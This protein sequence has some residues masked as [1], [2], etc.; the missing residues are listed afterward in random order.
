MRSV[1]QARRRAEEM[2]EGGST[3]AYSQRFHNCCLTEGQCGTDII[4][5]ECAGEPRL[6]CKKEKYLIGSSS[7]PSGSFLPDGCSTQI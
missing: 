2:A 1:C 6:N 5:D 7:R 3:A 4:V